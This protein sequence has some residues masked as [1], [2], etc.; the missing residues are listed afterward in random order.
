[1]PPSVSCICLTYNRPELLKRAVRDFLLQDYE[2][3]SELVIF[4]THPLQEIRLDHPMV[5]VVNWRPRPK[6]LGE[7]RNMAVRHASH[8]VI[9]TWDDDDRYRHDHISNMV[10]EL[11]DREAVKVNGHWV[12][13]GKGLKSYQHRGPI[14]QIAYTKGVF[15]RVGGYS[16]LDYGEDRD[17][18]EKLLDN[19]V[20]HEVFWSNQES[21]FTYNVCNGHLHASFNSS[22]KAMG[23]S[24]DYIRGVID[25]KAGGGRSLTVE[26]VRGEIAA[27]TVFYNIAGYDRLLKNY[28][29]F[30][31]NWPEDTAPLWTVEVIPPGSKPCI[32]GDRVTQVSVRNP[33]FHKE[34][35]I[36]YAVR[37]LPDEFTKVLWL[38]CDLVWS[39]YNWLRALPS[40][41]D[42][43]YSVQLWGQI[44]YLDRNKS[45]IEEG[46]S[47][48]K[49]L[50]RGKPGGGWATQ[51][52]FFTQLGLYTTGIVGGGDT[53]CAMG[54][55]GDRV[56]QRF[57]PVFRDRL[58]IYRNEVVRW[59]ADAMEITGGQATFLDER[60]SHLWHGDKDDRQYMDRHELLRKVDF[61][62]DLGVDGNGFRTWT[63][64]VGERRADALNR[65]IRRY[66]QNRREE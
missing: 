11:G 52:E 34:A 28:H 2:G 29:E 17:F 44:S 51:R 65:G 7:C 41:L 19:G 48:M 55:G 21:S 27:V 22:Y 3:K 6:S 33:F 40:L 50:S 47:V 30:R 31:S 46:A 18:Y 9:V 62:R 60:V 53:V 15:D 25:L 36:N 58:S 13:D 14:N 35:A 57:D 61:D 49:D 10:R 4:N 32:E 63:S 56:Y 23:K 5:K 16:D 45:V 38:D 42:T 64:K 24:K 54:L 26:P 37:E 8:P 43:H 66:F 39:N 1:M 59:V 12:D 20:V